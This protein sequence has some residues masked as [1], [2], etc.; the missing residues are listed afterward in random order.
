MPSNGYPY[1][2]RPNVRPPRE[3]VQEAGDD[4][5][6][7]VAKPYDLQ[8]IIDAIRRVIGL[9][10]SGRRRVDSPSGGYSGSG[11]SETLTPA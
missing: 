9:A 2:D 8:Q 7:I 10:R 1:S 4:V 5:I 3:I 11:S 6:A